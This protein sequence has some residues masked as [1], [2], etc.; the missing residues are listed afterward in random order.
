MKPVP[1]P[2][3]NKVLLGSS[4]GSVSPMPVFIC[5]G[6][7][8]FCWELSSEEKRQVITTGQVWLVVDALRPPPVSLHTVNPIVV[9]GEIS[10]G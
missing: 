9:D 10:L 7:T 3:Q 4:D 2:E 1:F 8:V 5:S 6:G